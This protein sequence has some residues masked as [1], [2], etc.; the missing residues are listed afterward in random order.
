MQNRAMA[1]ALAI[2]QGPVGRACL[3]EKDRVVRFHAHSGPHIIFKQS[4]A[5]FAYDVVG[6]GVAPCTR[7][8]VVL[9]NPM[10][11]HGNHF[12]GR[13]PSVILSLYLSAQWLAARFPWYPA[14]TV[15]ARPSIPVT[16][17]LRRLGDL[18]EQEMR[19]SRRQRESR[20]QSL[21][22]EIALAALTTSSRLPWG[23]ALCEATI[24]GFVAP[25]CI[26]ARISPA[27]SI[28]RRSHPAPVCPGHASSNCSRA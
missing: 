15:F 7:D 8:T 21:L 16:P 17:R 3:L 19:A 27:S 18:L 25:S 20:A 13:S 1:K 10:E 26:F 4:G 9:I 11:S 12:V 6:R 14:G 28:S 24:V 22:A 2:V 23:R 5:D